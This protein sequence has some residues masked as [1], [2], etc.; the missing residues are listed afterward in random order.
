LASLGYHKDGRSFERVV[1]ATIVLKRSNLNSK[2]KGIHK[3]FSLNK[4]VPQ[5]LLEVSN[6][7]VVFLSFNY[8]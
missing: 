5:Q 2:W 7:K 3:H 8:T 4:F 6:K 1:R